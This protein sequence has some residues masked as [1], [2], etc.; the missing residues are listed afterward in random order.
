MSSYIQDL[1]NTYAAN[2]I[3]EASKSTSRKKDSGG[4]DM[5]DFLNLMVV[6]LQSQTIDNTAD[7]SDMLNQLVQ[8]QMITA[9]T[10]M[11]DASVMSYASSLVGKEVTIGTINSSGQ[12]DE[13]VL[14]VIGTGV[15]NDEQVIFT[16][17]GGTYKL[18]S[19]MAVGRLPDK[20]GAPDGPEEGEEPDNPADPDDKV[21]PDPGD[22]SSD[23]SGDTP[24]GEVPAGFDLPSVGR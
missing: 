8:M 2:A 12:V 7:T 17:D 6:Q 5:T 20:T 13:K 9:M 15:A 3:K 24:T 23:G 1:G 14:K 16:E 18:S 19:V 11:T 21:D 10:N 22:G 4:L